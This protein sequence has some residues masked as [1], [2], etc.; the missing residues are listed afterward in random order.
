M[1]LFI[2]QRDVWACGISLKPRLAVAVRRFQ[3]AARRGVVP[4]AALEAARR[5]EVGL[6]VCEVARHARAGLLKLAGEA[7]QARAAGV[8]EGEEVV[9]L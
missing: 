2:K 8:A 6:V 1:F 5:L 4:G 9:V 7:R 3:R